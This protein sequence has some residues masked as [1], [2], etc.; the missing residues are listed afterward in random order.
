MLKQKSKEVIAYIDRQEIL[1]YLQ[2]T[3]FIPHK[4][5][6]MQYKYDFR[7]SLEND[8]TKLQVIPYVVIRNKN[9]IVMYKRAGAEERLQSQYSIGFGGHVNID[10]KSIDNTILREL[11]EELNLDIYRN[12]LNFLGYI[13]SNRTNVDK[14]H[15]AYAYEY[16]LPR[17]SLINI[18]PDSSEISNISFCDFEVV[19]EYPF[20]EEWSKLLI[21]NLR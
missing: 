21:N 4:F 19:R 16:Y 17:Q 20:L 10:D 7:G 12:R 18:E 13:F 3:G 8:E 2:P 15:L 6:E 9:Y 1:N 14:V 5:V 11:K